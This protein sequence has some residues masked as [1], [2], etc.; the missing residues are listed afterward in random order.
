MMESLSKIALSSPQ[1][2]HSA[3]T[4]GLKH[5]WTFLQRTM[6][7]IG[8]LFKP[9]DDII[10]DKFIPALLG[11]RLVTDE[12][13]KLLSLPARLGGL[14][15]ENPMITSS[16]KYTNSLK[17]T[18]ELTQ[19]IIEQNMNLTI[20]ESVNKLIKTDIK[21]SIALTHKIEMENVY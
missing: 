19:S 20:N 11:G 12:E 1:A 7:N 8:Y 3:F 13:S 6:P 5:K 18:A 14:D 4:H 16:M 17:A 10:R 15:I 2:A 21:N 9:L